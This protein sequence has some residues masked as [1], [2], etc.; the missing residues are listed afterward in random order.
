MP[1]SRDAKKAEA[2]NFNTSH[3]DDDDDDNK[4]S[5]DDESRHA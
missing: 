2:F 3:N 1:N 5:N 4:D